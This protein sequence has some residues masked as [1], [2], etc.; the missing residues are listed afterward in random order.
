MNGAALVHIHSVGRRLEEMLIS[1][2]VQAGEMRPDWGFE[3][4]LGAG[5]GGGCLR[6]WGGEW[7]WLERIVSALQTGRQAAVLTVGG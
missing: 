1:L 7:G 6:G 2:L 5:G 3:W 4:H